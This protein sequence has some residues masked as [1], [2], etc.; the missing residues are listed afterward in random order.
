[1][2]RSADP[3]TSDGGTGPQDLILVR[4]ALRGEP[5][6]VEGVLARLS[7]IAR[8]VC[9]LNRSLG[10][11]LVADSLAGQPGRCEEQEYDSGDAVRTETV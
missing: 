6:A 11:G 10:Y 4:S 7:C 3:L 9:R 2:A 5:E 1:M 8:F